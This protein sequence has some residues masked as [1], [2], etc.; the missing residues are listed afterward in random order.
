MANEGFNPDDFREYE[1]R[2]AKIVELQNRATDGLKGYGSVLKD[3]KEV[4][5]NLKSIKEQETKLMSEIENK[6][7]R[8]KRLLASSGTLQGKNKKLVEAELK[9][10]DKEIAAR[11]EGLKYARE[12][13]SVLQENA[14]ILSESAN[15]GNLLSAS[16]VSVGRG[17][18]GIYKSLKGV[19]KELLKEMKTVQMTEQSMGILNKNAN[20]FR[21]NMYKAAG[22]TNQL[23]VSAGDL[24][25]IQGA[26]SEQ[27][28]KSVVLSEQGLIAMG[29]MAKGTMMGVEGTAEMVSNLENFGLSAIGSHKIMSEMMETSTKMGVNSVKVTAN[30]KKNLQLANKYHF[31]DG[32]KGMLRLAASAAK[33]RINMDGIASMADKV[34]RPEGAVE[35]ASRL[36]TMGGEFSKLADPFTLMFKA[37]NDF[38]GFT[39]D[40]INASKEFSKFNS[41]TGEFDISGLGY[42]RIKEIADITGLAATDIAQMSKD[43]AKLDQIK[44]NIGG[45]I[46]DDDNKEFISS[47][48][49]FNQATKE[50]EVAIGSNTFGINQLTDKQVTLMRAEKQTLKERAKQAQTFDETWN[51]LK[52]TFKT[53]LFPMLNGL[54]EGLKEPLNSFMEWSRDSG[55][56]KKL[57]NTAKTIGETAGKIIKTIGK[58]LTDSPIMTIGATIAGIG[59]FKAAQWIA[60]GVSLGI[61]FNMTASS[62]GVGGSLS[63]GASKMFGGGKTMA[64]RAIGKAGGK[65]GGSMGMKGV[66]MGLGMGIAGYGL[67]YARENMIDDRDSGVGKAMGIGSSALTGAAMGMMLGPIGGLIGGLAGAAYG[68]YQEFKDDPNKTQPNSLSAYGLP[69][70]TPVGPPV[71][72]AIL[73]NGMITPIDTKDEVFQVSKPGGAFDKSSNNKQS[74]D[75]IKVSFGNP[76]RIDGKITLVSGENENEIK[77]DDPILLRNLS[78]L[79]QQQLSKA[80]NGGKMSPNPA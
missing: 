38:E 24:A 11:K 9:E 3:I 64:G 10:L 40:I 27:I 5:R 4:A 62:G 72:D 46:T 63:R 31:K 17:A 48:A 2:L 59:L 23:G 12:K 34:F 44:M 36:Q 15:S 66:G 16:F 55:G 70:G 49:S 20:A 26:Y 45:G 57:F 30:L 25:K 69:A 80:I 43:A 14:A 76:M 65:L 29:E 51:N 54:S 13:T 74:S 53:L 7:K 79:I 58:W 33:V 35:M 52:D 19:S 50:Y 78:N 22:T 61:G 41:E 56:F 75:N 47:I 6:E 1:E 37:R 18:L 39:N 68:A 32:V 28:G 77:L 60:N 73:A 71:N 8:R 67:D 42:D 21:L